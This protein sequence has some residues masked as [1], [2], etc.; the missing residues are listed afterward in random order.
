MIKFSF[1]YREIIILII[2]ILLIY[3]EYYL[4]KLNY[5]YIALIDGIIAFIFGLFVLKSLIKIIKFYP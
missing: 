5:L 3:I 1:S 4:I 2:F